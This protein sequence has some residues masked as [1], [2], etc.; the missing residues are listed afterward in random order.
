MR[1]VTAKTACKALLDVFARFR[2]PEVSCGDQGSNFTPRLTSQVVEKMG[3]E[4]RFSN[5]EHPQSNGIEERWNGTFKFMLRHVIAEQDRNWD[6]CI[7]CMLW[8]HREI[9]HEITGVSPFQ[10]V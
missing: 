1:P 3:A 9:P 4:I 2:T 5:S 6:Q 7:Q 10:M 8:T